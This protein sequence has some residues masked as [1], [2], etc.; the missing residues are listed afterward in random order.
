M[1]PYVILVLVLIGIFTPVFWALGFKLPTAF[2]V[3]VI[4]VSLSALI[5]SSYS[6]LARWIVGA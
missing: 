3:T 2:L 1:G 6:L 5:A 4:L